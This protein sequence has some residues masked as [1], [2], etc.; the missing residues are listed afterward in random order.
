[1]QDLLVEPRGG[2]A[3]EEAVE[4]DQE[5][6]LGVRAFGGLADGAGFGETF[7]VTTHGAWCVDK[8]LK[9]KG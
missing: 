4:P 6:E 3:G 8:V 1:M 7:G 2:A 5:K 9:K